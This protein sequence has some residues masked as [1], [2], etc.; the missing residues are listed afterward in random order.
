MNKHRVNDLIPKAYELCKEHGINM[1]FRGQISAFGSAIATGSLLA[2]VAFFSDQ[3]SAS[4]DR[5]ELM[6]VINK[7]LKCP[8]KTLFDTVKASNDTT[9]LKEEILDCAIAV[10]LALNLFP[11]KNSADSSEGGGE[12]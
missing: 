10:K 6:V 3:G 1:A 7:M 8:E 5:S 4:I 9:A 2:A 12:A 11:A